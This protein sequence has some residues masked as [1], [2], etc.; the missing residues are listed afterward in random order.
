MEMKLLKHDPARGQDWKKKE[1]LE[2]FGH[3]SD[4]MRELETAVNNNHR[5]GLK[6]ADIA[7]HVMM[8]ADLA[9]ELESV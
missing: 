1:P 3:I 7:N 8:L 2:L 6:A 4:L 9:G 5:I